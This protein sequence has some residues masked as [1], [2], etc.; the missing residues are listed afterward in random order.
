MVKKILRATLTRDTL[1][2]VT[3]AKDMTE[4]A[5]IRKQT[6]S[7]MFTSPRLCTV[8]PPNII[9]NTGF[10]RAR[11]ER[12]T[13]IIYPIIIAE[14]MYLFYLQSK[15]LKCTCVEPVNEFII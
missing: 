7:G 6:I 5:I 9:G 12:V 15:R 4:M 3:N 11:R 1:L 2:Q 8:S 14:V 13:L 10:P